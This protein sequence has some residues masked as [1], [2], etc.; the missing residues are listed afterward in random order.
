MKLFKAIAALFLVLN[1]LTAAISAGSESAEVNIKYQQERMAYLENEF[2][3]D[4]T[5]CDESKFASFDIDEAIESG[6]KF[7]EVQ[8]LGTH[9]SYQIPPTDEYKQLFSTLS[10]LTFGLVSEEIAQFEMDCLTEQFELGIRS[11]EIDIETVDKGGNVSF[12]VSHDPILD[13]TSSC[14]DFAKALEEIR[15]WS[16]HNPGHLPITVIIEPKKGVVPVN[17][18]KNFT[19]KYAQ[20]LDEV[21]REKMGDKLLTP[22]DMMGDFENFREMREND[23]WLTLEETMGKVMFLLHDT[24]VTSKYISQDETIKSQ[25][26]FPMLRYGDR[27]ES[28]T[29]FIIDNKPDE[30]VNHKEESLEKCNLIVRTRADSFPSFSDERYINADESLSQIISTD[31]PVKKSP[32]GYHQ[33]TFD[34][35]TVK[36]Q[37]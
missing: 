27:N 15:M 24:T 13:N 19:I 23:G 2:Y 20:I 28:Y 25:A 10:D 31:Y 18:M 37:K 17:D 5:P 8:F 4:Y 21:I 30:A 34:G 16:D 29:S 35:Y 22:K 7:N 32:K 1:Y 12:I 11:V 14:Y 9:N 6:V 33:Y 26:M 3:K 36:L